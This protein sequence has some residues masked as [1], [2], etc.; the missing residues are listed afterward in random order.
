MA[1]Q[2]KDLIAALDAVSDVSYGSELERLQV[3]TAARRALA[4]IETPY[5]RAW[6]YCFE[7]PVV[8]AALQTFID[9]GLWTAW[10]KQGGGEKTVHEL[11]KLTS[12]TIETNLLRMPSIEL[13]TYLRRLIAMDRSFLP[14]TGCL[15]HR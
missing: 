2:A 15:Q 14:F 6:G 9:L 3:R 12:P 10:A 5:E 11:V 13:S 4:K 1:P 8:N 7:H